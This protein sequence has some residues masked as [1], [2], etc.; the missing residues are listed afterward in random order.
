MNLFEHI[1]ELEP[2]LKAYNLRANRLK[3]LKKAQEIKKVID[4]KVSNLISIAGI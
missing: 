3:E 2:I 1:Q 4:S